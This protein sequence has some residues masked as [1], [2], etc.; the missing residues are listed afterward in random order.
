MNYGIAKQTDA[1]SCHATHDPNSLDTL[2]QCIPDHVLADRHKYIEYNNCVQQNGEDFFCFIPLT[3]LK[4]YHGDP[5]DNDQLPDINFLGA[6]IPIASQL[7]PHRWCYH[8][9]Q[10]WDKQLPDLIEYSFL[11]DFFWDGIL[12]PS[13]TNHMSANT[14]H[15]EQYISKELSYGAIHGPYHEKPFPMHVSPL[16]VRDSQTPIKNVPS[17][18]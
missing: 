9:A 5:I 4:V 18:T 15:V 11:L 7:K 2:N 3:T 8:L 17:W 14:S 13:D 6:R 1:N 16:M 12:H 10:F